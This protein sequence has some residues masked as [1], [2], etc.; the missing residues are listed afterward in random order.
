MQKDYLVRSGDPS[1]TGKSGDTVF[2]KV[3][4]DESQRYFKSELNPSLKH[5]KFGILATAN[6]APD[7]NDSQFYITLS[8]RSL[9]TLDGKHTIFGELVEGQ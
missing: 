6:M 4:K 3:H 5:N 9:D 8:K 1:N 7:Q 2:R